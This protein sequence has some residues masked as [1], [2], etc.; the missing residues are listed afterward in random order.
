VVFLYVLVNVAVF[1]LYAT[2]TGRHPLRDAKA[3]DKQVES[4][5]L[6]K[7]AAGQKPQEPWPLA[8]AARQGGKGGRKHGNP[9]AA[10]DDSS[11]QTPM[12]LMAQ[13]AVISALLLVLVPG[14]LRLTSNATLLDLGLSFKDWRRQM[15]VGVVAAFLMT[16]A[17][18]A[19]QS[20]AARVWPPQKHP[21]EEMVRDEFTVSVAILALLSAMVLA[22]MIEE[23]LFRG[24]LQRWL[25]KVA[26]A[27]SSA[28]PH[29]PQ[30]DPF[31]EYELSG[32]WST[33]IPVGQLREENTSGRVTGISPQHEA[34][35]GSTLPI[36]VAS[37]CFAVMHLPQWPAPI[38]IFLL[39]IAL[40]A[41]Y[42]RTGSLIAIITMHGTFN[43]FS[44][45]ALL[46]EML[47]R[48]LQPHNLG[49]PQALGCPNFLTDFLSQMG[50]T[51]VFGGWTGE[52]GVVL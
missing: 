37:L 38:S 46:L 13:F 14:L 40:G 41:I 23:V 21:L 9:K 49:L 48:S 44:T 3:T 50:H 22:P 6:D 33:E 26:G 45:L 31:E 4:G 10:T 34:Q 18:F 20:L 42:Q 36:I 16:P 35:L 1:R 8:D 17:V 52:W 2:A 12:E 7:A 30:L 25:S 28:P 47:S 43:G 39:S 15:A 51:L 11:E 19:V 27:A 32:V 5:K 29:T 24:V